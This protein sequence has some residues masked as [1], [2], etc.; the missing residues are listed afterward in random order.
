[1]GMIGNQLAAGTALTIANDSFNGTG[2]ATAFTLSQTVSA[3]TDIEV[4]VDNVQQSPYDSSYSVSGT[5]LTFSAA[6]AAGTNNIY[7]MYNASKHI[8]TNQVIPDDG[9]VVESKLGAAAVTEAKLGAAAVTTAKLHD[10][11]VTHGK[12][13]AGSILQTVQT[14]WYTTHDTTSTSFVSVDD[15]QVNI[16]P[17]F[18]NSQLLIRYD[19]HQYCRNGDLHGIA[20]YFYLPSTG[21]W[22]V[23][24]SNTTFNEV[25]RLANL[26][27]SAVVWGMQCFEF[28]IGVPG[29]GTEQVSFKVYHKSYSGNSERINDNGPGS[30][31]TVQEIA[32]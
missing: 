21:S 17:K 23:L 1:M 4:L 32:Q 24:T 27:S 20:P 5:T 15:S 22:S 26:S 2:S 16:T 6:P 14:K 29:T 8:S 10:N 28:L 9:S 30:S 12:L 7:V 18:A 19:I 25:V 11:A 3:V 31:I 13:P